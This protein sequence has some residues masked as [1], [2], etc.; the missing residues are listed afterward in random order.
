MANRVIKYIDKCKQT[1]ALRPGNKPAQTHNSSHSTPAPLTFLRI[2]FF[3][4]SASCWYSGICRKSSS[5]QMKLTV[6][7]IRATAGRTRPSPF[8]TPPA[9]VAFSSHSLRAPLMTLFRSRRPRVRAAGL[10]S[11]R[12][13]VA[14]SKLAGLERTQVARRLHTLSAASLPVRRSACLSVTHTPLQLW[15]CDW[16]FR[17]SLKPRGDGSELK[18]LALKDKNNHLRLFFQ[19]L[20]LLSLSGLKVQMFFWIP[21]WPSVPADGPNHWA[22]V[23]RCSRSREMFLCTFAAPCWAIGKSRGWFAVYLFLVQGF[24]SGICICWWINYEWTEQYIEDILKNK[25][26]IIKFYLNVAQH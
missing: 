18:W 3:F 25:K 17:L 11:L 14:R 26:A 22:D 24:A 12:R 23:A 6:H 21:K 15:Y 1:C 2:P 16:C 8:N 20:K 19:L 9:G 13:P 10:A 5:Q 7:P 4:S